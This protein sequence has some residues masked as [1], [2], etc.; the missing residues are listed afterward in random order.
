MKA[1]AATGG[2]IC[3][4]FIGGF[5][6]AEGD[7]RPA[8]IAE[9]I[10]HIADLTG[11]EHLCAGSDYVYNYAGTLDWVLRNPEM[12]PPEMGY[13]SPSHMG[14][15]GEI[16]GVVRYLQEENGWTDE[17]IIGLIGGNL[18]RVYEANWQ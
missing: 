5:L 6:N 4:N 7:A 3:V 2:A 11:P 8:R 9:H 15:P 18:L 17:E 14:M 1:V 10:Q 16:W 12:F 13:A